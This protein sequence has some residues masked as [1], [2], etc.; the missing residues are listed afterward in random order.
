M[1]ILLAIL[2]III[3]YWPF[4]LFVSFILIAAILGGL[5]CLWYLGEKWRDEDKTNNI[6]ESSK[7]RP[8]LHELIQER[9]PYLSD[10]LDYF[11]VTGLPQI[12]DLIHQIIDNLIRTYIFPWY[13]Q[14]S[15]NRSFPNSLKRC[16]C[17]TLT[18]LSKRLKRVDWTVLLTRH[19]VDD[20]ASHFRLFRLSNERR[21]EQDRLVKEGLLKKSEDLESIFFDMELEME[22]MYCRDLISTSTAY[23]SACLHDLTDILLFLLMP[24]EEFRSRPLR[25]LIRE[26]LIGRVLIPLLN[27]VCDSDFI[28]HCIIVLLS[29]VKLTA[30]DF[31]MIMHRCRSIQDLE[32][33]LEAAYGER[34]VLCS[35]D[36]S[37]NIDDAKKEIQALTAL[38]ELIKRRMKRLENSPM[39]TEAH[40][41]FR[42]KST[43]SDRVILPIT[44]VL[45]NNVA[46][47]YF[48]D[49]L[50]EIGY[51][52]YLDCYLAIEGFK[53][54]VAHQ[55]RAM[56]GGVTSDPD[57]QETMK[58]ASLFLYNQYL[59]DTA[60][61]RIPLE[62]SLVNTFLVRMRNDEPS[63][64][65]FDHIQ[66]EIVSVLSSERAFYNDF[67]QSSFYEKM[68]CDLEITDLDEVSGKSLNEE[69]FLTRDCKLTVE[70]GMLGVG[71][72][73]KGPG[74][75]FYAVYS[76]IVRRID[77]TGE[78]ISSWNVIRRYSDF[79]N[80]NSDI[81]KKYPTLKRIEFPAK[82]TFNNLKQNFL[83]KRCKD[84]NKYMEQ[85]TNTSLL[86]STPGLYDDLLD[87]LNQ[88]KYIG[89]SQ[90][91]SKK[92]ALAMVT[93]I[94]DK[95]KAIKTVVTNVPDHVTKMGNEINKA[96][97]NI[98]KNNTTL[99]HTEMDF[100]RVASSLDLEG[101]DESI[102]LRVLLLFV[103][104]L[105]GVDG[106]NQ[107]FKSR[108]IAAVRHFLHAAFGTS[109]NKLIID[110]VKDKSSELSVAKYLTLLRNSLKIKRVKPRQNGAK[111]RILSQTL[112]Y[113]AI[114]PEL[115]FVFGTTSS[116]NAVANF[117]E[118]IHQK[119]LNRRLCYVLIE[120]LLL[121]LFPEGNFPQLL[122]KLHSKSP[123]FIDI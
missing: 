9:Q 19:V 44:L 15:R 60:P 21:M 16:A 69:V 113:A 20:V 49:Y 11:V 96:A 114:P 63:D 28:N 22:M 8:H 62:E 101:D 97:S 50:A 109:L 78:T 23:E 77:K 51:Q 68:L 118:M 24:S 66:S 112:M 84:L 76:V 86:N 83:E 72:Q 41:V 108:V 88:K 14:L 110:F 10:R 67:T 105:F 73:N 102:P 107:W 64:S 80:F 93:P 70:V 59:S 91:F 116:L 53:S 117:S 31:L 30:D 56:A 82:K 119:A 79:Y 57:F 100:Q 47:T 122:S 75:Q 74:A 54:S 104:E 34:S 29:D 3:S 95:V 7:F 6:I 81:Q 12:D 25:F 58:E 36:N 87:F 111:T 90:K 55:L 121:T 94:I 46:V 40:T 123:R 65:W 42:K 115:K 26:I 85:L 71:R 89:I 33:I 120:R 13:S 18:T 39:K 48:S 1:V 98:M 5:L 99:K 43:E 27:K 61:R 2:G 17:R 52:H 103:N 4:L 106:R 92:I 45:T 32:V 37:A 38:I 35:R